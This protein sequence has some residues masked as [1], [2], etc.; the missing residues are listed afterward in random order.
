MEH[1]ELLLLHSDS[2][3]SVHRLF[4]RPRRQLVVTEQPTR[5]IH[6]YPSFDLVPSGSAGYCVLCPVGQSLLSFL[7]SG[8]I[9]N[10]EAL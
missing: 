1:M 9:R 4:S 7:G 8:E 2:M 3:H 5:H 10:A 6:T